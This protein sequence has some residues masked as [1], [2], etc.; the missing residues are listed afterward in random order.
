MKPLSRF[1]LY[2]T[3]ESVG[4]LYVDYAGVEIDV[5][6]DTQDFNASEPEKL[7][8][9]ENL[10]VTSV[11][12]GNPKIDTVLTEYLELLNNGDGR[13]LKE[14]EMPEGLLIS[15]TGK[16]VVDIR[17]IEPN[18][19]AIRQAIEESGGA[20]T[21]CYR[22]SEGTCSAIVNLHDLP[23][24]ASHSMIAS[25]S[26]NVVESNAG[27]ID[28]EAT[29]SMLVDEARSLF[30]FDGTGTK[31]CV[32]STTFDCAGVDITRNTNATQDILLG[33]LP[34]LD[35][36]DIIRDIG[37]DDPPFASPACNDEGRAMMQLIHDIAPGADLGFDTALL[38]LSA[39]ADSIVEM[40]NRDCD[41]IVDDIIYFAE[42]M[43]QDDL[44][45]QADR[46]DTLSPQNR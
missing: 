11:Y 29:R 16:A 10:F 42:T 5:E 9:D 40:V 18:N 22:L 14:I 37:P 41:I 23:T 17:G 46:L 34:P 4:A 3:I 19:E 39:F 6:A 20:V 8:D 25:I 1:V 21:G 26:S 44:V 15:N 2:L 7:D 38:G 43:Y 32:L 24:M 28:S 27:L 36:M 31:V 12:E 45:A 13:R 35:R 33:D 30:G